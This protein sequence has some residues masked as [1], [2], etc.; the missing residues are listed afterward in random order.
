MLIDGGASGTPPARDAA[1][2]ELRTLRE[3]SPFVDLLGAG[4][5]WTAGAFVSAGATITLAD[6]AGP[7][8]AAASPLL[9]AQ[10]KPPFPVT[11]RGEFGYA[12]DAGTSP[13]G[14]ALVHMNVGAL[15]DSGDPRDW[16]DGELGTIERAAR[17]FSGRRG[18][19]GAA[20]YHPRRLNDRRGS[21]QRRPSQPRPARV[22]AALHARPLGAGADLRVRHLAGRP[23]GARRRAGLARRSRGG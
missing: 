14:L 16:Q 22:R 3:G 8:V 6:P 19:D 4:L 7:S 20:W 23:P 15:A 11:N 13:P 9:P 18:M 2:S 21:R 17:V 10:F 1:R 12:L 5:P